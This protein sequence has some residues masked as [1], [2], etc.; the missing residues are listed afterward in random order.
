MKRS[1]EQGREDEYSAAKTAARCVWLEAEDQVL[2]EMAEKYK[3]E[4]WNTVAKAVSVF[5]PADASR[6]TA[7][8]CRERWHNQ[9]NP[10]VQ[11]GPLGPQEERKVFALHQQFG[12]RWSKI[13]GR[14]P[15]RTDNVVKNYFFCRL[16]KLVRSIKRGKGKA[17]FP[18]TPSDLEQTLYLLDYLY[19]Y[20][21]SPERNENILK[22]INTQTKKRKNNGDK[23]IN[24]MVESEGISTGKICTFARSLMA[25]SPPNLKISN[26]E[27]YAY[28]QTLAPAEPSSPSACSPGPRAE[29]SKGATYSSAG[30]TI[31]SVKICVV[32]EPA[33]NKSTHESV[34]K[35]VMESLKL[36]VPSNFVL[37]PKPTSDDFRPTFSFSVYSIQSPA[38]MS[39]LFETM[40]VSSRQ[41][42]ICGK[43]V[44]V[45]VDDE[46]RKNEG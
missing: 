6:K 42:S 44:R 20:Y 2:R 9:L 24:R 8:Q 35:L 43:H 38:S 21:I 15:G 1:L 14:L 27:A 5:T 23:Y 41:W 32:S 36:P 40:Q 39:K 4:Y 45:A 29:D 25:T 11:L 12:N 10:L 22:A 17:L 30:S 19:R 31:C 34:S 16:R 18:K 26:F 7:K 37:F 33:P 13:A 3:G 46:F 28:L